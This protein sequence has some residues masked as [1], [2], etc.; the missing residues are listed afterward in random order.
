MSDFATAV[1]IW[2]VSDW[3]KVDTVSKSWTTP[4]RHNKS[5][6]GHVFHI[7][8]PNG[9]KLELAKKFW[10]CTSPKRG[11]CRFSQIHSGPSI[12]QDEKH[13]SVY[14]DHWSHPAVHKFTCNVL[15]LQKKIEERD[16]GKYELSDGATI[17]VVTPTIFDGG[18]V[19]KKMELYG[20]YGTVAFRFPIGY[21]GEFTPLQLV[22]V[23]VDCGNMV[24]SYTVRASRDYLNEVTDEKASPISVEE[25]SSSSIT[26]DPFFVKE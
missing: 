12:S 9:H 17:E 13:A 1:T 8:A 20:E 15:R 7:Y 10:T 5:A 19:F 6:K 21:S 4:D 14:I 18:G 3:V 16:L 24:Y 2:E 23:D 22:S 26:Y 11:A 25:P